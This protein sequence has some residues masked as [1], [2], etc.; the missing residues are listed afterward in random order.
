MATEAAT[1]RSAAGKRPRILLR[2]IPKVLASMLIV[3]SAALAAGFIAFVSA[4]ERSEPRALPS[5]D[6]IVALTGGP[7]RIADAVTWLSEGRGQR[8]LISGVDTQTPLD[9]VARDIPAMR[10]W[11]HCCIDV[12]RQARNTVGNA[13]ESGRWAAHRGYRSLVVVTSSHHMPRAMVE[14]RRSMPDVT[15][16]PAPVVTERLRTLDIWRDPALVRTLG[17]EYGKFIFAYVRARLTGPLRSDD[18]TASHP[19]RSVL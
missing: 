15:L 17:H 2:F 6:G 4:I 12:D 7:E 18:M 3:A 14:F 5:A 8:L 10:A 19:R 9:H 11:L 1:E 13:L 16:I